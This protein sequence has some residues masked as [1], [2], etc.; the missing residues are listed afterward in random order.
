MDLCTYIYL[1]HF[2]YI[3][4]MYIYCS[5]I[6]VQGNVYSKFTQIRTCTPV[7]VLYACAYETGCASTCKKT[8]VQQGGLQRVSK[9]GN[10]HSS[11]AFNASRNAYAYDVCVWRYTTRN[12]CDVTYTVPEMHV[13]LRRAYLC[14]ERVSLMQ[15]NRFAVTTILPCLLSRE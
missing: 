11:C 15:R 7:Y 3:R 9:K 1:S 5:S 13:R 14:A 8:S 6:R 12:M 4:S 2:L 10:N